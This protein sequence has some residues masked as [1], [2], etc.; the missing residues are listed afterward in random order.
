MTP[1]GVPRCTAVAD[2]RLSS[3]GSY[4]VR[5]PPE[6]LTVMTPRPA[7]TPE[8]AT[9]PSPA[10][11]TGWPT[12]ADRST[13]RCPDDHSLWGCS[14]RREIAG[15]GD[16]GQAKPPYDATRVTS[17][18]GPPV[19]ARHVVAGADA[20]ADADLA[21]CQAEGASG[22]GGDAVAETATA[23][24]RT[25]DA[26]GTRSRMS[27]RCLSGQLR[28]SGRGPSVGSGTNRHT[29]VDGAGSA[30]GERGI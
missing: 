26:A 24:M 2:A 4:V 27:P 29:P 9:T 23:T 13:P 14:N 18:A 28:A 30:R 25:A 7:T 6:C 11:S 21:P 22:A 8:K 17:P 20:V 16:N 10:L 15:R 3:T 12:A 1:I 5:S 19:P